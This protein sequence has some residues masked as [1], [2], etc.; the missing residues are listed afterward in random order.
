MEFFANYVIFCNSKVL[1]GMHFRRT[2]VDIEE[3]RGQEGCYNLFESMDVEE[4]VEEDGFH[5][6][7]LIN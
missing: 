3:V 5:G 2:D 6:L 7:E 4:E 1:R